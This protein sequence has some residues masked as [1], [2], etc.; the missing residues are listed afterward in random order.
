MPFTSNKLGKNATFRTTA[1][2]SLL[3]TDFS[4]A[5]D[6]DQAGTVQLQGVNAIGTG[7]SFDTAFAN[8]DF[9]RAVVNSTAI[10]VRAINQV[11]NA[12]F[13][14]VTSTFS[15]ANAATTYGKSE[16]VERV[17]VDG[18]KFSSNGSWTVARGA[19]TVMVLHGTD[20]F[21]FAADG[22]SV[23]DDSGANVVISHSASAT[24]TIVLEFSKKSR[25]SNNRTEFA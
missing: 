7:T 9:V 18:V 16:T 6:G 15:G 5:Y 2:A 10:D 24:G 11:V 17:T 8:G 4:V 19:N 23:S 3:L 21:N 25:T 12:T 22:Q 1:N 14:N 13:M 20:S